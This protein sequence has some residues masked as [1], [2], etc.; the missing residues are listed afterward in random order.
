MKK[1]INIAIDGP[2][3]SGKSTVAKNVAKELGMTYVDTGAMYRAI[4]WKLLDLGIT[5]GD[6]TSINDALKEITISFDADN[7]VVINDKVLTNEIRTNEVSNITSKVSSIAMVRQKLTVIQ[8]SLV[9]DKNVIMDGRDIG[10]V[11]IPDAELK[12]FLVAS[13]EVRAQRRME[14]LKN[15]GHDEIELEDL[16][17]EIKARDLADSTRDIAPLKKAD[18][19]IE[20]DTSKLTRDEVLNKIIDLAKDKLK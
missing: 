2:A 9:S 8:K 6:E 19:A 5:S 20:I 11:V 16:I 3:A 12:I 15:N 7:R 17:N 10:T 13:P 18:D 4:A 1:L 14:D